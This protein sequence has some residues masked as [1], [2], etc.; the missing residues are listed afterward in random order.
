M[1]KTCKHDNVP[2][3]PECETD[4][5]PQ[6]LT[7]FVAQTQQPWTVPYGANK[8]WVTNNEGRLKHCLADWHGRFQEH[9]AR[10]RAARHSKERQGARP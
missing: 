2:H 3:C 8:W 4:P 9:R 6:T 7:L 10:A 1:I 5:D